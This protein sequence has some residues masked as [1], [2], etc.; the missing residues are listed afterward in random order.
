[1]FFV[2]GLCNLYEQTTSLATPGATGGDSSGGY[3]G[4]LELQEVVALVVAPAARKG[5]HGC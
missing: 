5:E 2:T 1:M 3:L 4:Y